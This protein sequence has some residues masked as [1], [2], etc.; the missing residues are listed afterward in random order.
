MKT[1]FIFTSLLLAFTFSL[2]PC[3]A[4]VPQGFN[5]QAVARDKSGNPIINGTL[6]VRLSILSDTTGFYSSGNGIYLWEE[7]HT[8]INTN[9]SGIFNLTLGT[10]IKYQGSENSF[11]DINWKEGSYFIGTK[12]STDNGAT[13][14]IMGAA[15]LWSVPYS[16]IAG[17]IDGS[18]NK[19]TVAGITPEMNEPLFEVKNK[20]GQTVFAVYNDA[21]NIFIPNSGTKAK[22]GGFAIGSFD[23][24]KD[25]PQDFFIV[26]SDSIRMYINSN[27]PSK[28]LTKGGF[29]IG[30]FNEL[31][32]REERYFGLYGYSSVD[33]IT[34][35][36]QIMWYPKKEAFMAGRIDILHPD[37]VGKNSFTTGYKNIAKGDFS[38]ALGYEAIARGNYSTAIGRRAISGE[39]SY[40]LG[41]FSTA[42]GN[43]AYAIGSEAKASANKSFA[44]GVESIASAQGSMGIGFQSEASGIYSTAIG[45]QSKAKAETAHAFGLNSEAS[46]FGSLAL[47]MFSNASQNY[48]TSIGFHSSA[49]NEYSMALGYYAS[50]GG[51]DSYAI[52]SYAE[53]AGKKSF[54]IGSYGLNDNDTQNENLKT[55]TSGD[56]S[57]AFGMGAQATQLGAMAL[58]VNSTASGSKATS[59]GF[60][61]RAEGDF[62]TS[63]GYRSVANGFKA[64]S[65][66][67]HY[68]LTFNKLDWIYNAVTG[69]WDFVRNPEILDKSNVAEGNYSIA[70]GNGNSAKDGG[71]A[72]GTNNSAN[73][74][75]SVAI[76]FSNTADSVFSFV[77]GLNNS[78]IGVKAFAL[79]EGLIAQSANS[80][81]VGAYNLPLGAFNRWALSEPLFIVG[82]GNPTSRSNAFMILKNG[83]VVLSPDLKVGTGVALSV[84]ADGMIMKASSSIRYKTD[85]SAVDNIDWLYSLQPVS[86]V[87]K[88]DQEKSRQYGLI[89]ED[90][91]IVNRDLVVFSGNAPEGV[92]YIGLIPPIIKALQNQKEITD[93]LLTKNKELEAENN[94]LRARLESLELL[95]NSLIEK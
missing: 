26:T 21:V 37:S 79:G 66:G 91:A 77:A 75:G 18:V 89:A 84:G 32:G 49:A 93:I 34:N 23:Q 62:S 9:S 56:Y 15:K 7:T 3:I 86:F 33:T 94:E 81:T 2:L 31:K 64:I 24:T 88:S 11:S 38:H 85:I 4:Q 39:N 65:I 87:Y 53:A 27:P 74:F 35:A 13:W 68:N 95:V 12:I 52:G 5:Y 30:G 45:F 36:S 20:D 71:L 73:S 78:S 22:K 29:A 50:A 51:L 61:T 6:W 47:G 40:A 92:N 14:K 17:D 54:A 41:N 25:T 44:L 43:D 8:G 16:M 28:T 58:G 60:G 83:N 76:G 55:F 59:I 1:K 69:D 72:L 90:V 67:S 19:L 48:S 57:L 82:N 42:L 63:L 80:F 10:G 46:G 70:I